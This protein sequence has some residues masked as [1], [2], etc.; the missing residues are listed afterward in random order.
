[1]ASVGNLGDISKSVEL[2]VTQIT[3]DAFP[4]LS[5]DTAQ[6]LIMLFSLNTENNDIKPRTSRFQINTQD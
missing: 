3:T 4:F 5:A 6:L 1:M 2:K